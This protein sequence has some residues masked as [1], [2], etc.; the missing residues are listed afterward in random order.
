MLEVNKKVVDLIM[1]EV[2]I[3]VGEMLKIFF[4]INDVIFVDMV[5]ISDVVD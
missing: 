2:C 1:G 4:G 3:V 5:V